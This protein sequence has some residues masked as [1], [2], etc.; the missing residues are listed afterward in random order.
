MKIT[1]IGHSC[2]KVEKDGYSV[3]IDPYEDG[4]V[5][6]L[7]PVKEQASAV[8]CSHE[9]GDHNHREGVKLVESLAKPL[10]I[11]MIDT[12]HDDAKGAMRGPNKIHIL[13]D[14]TER[15]AHLGDLGCMLDESQVEMLK[16]V[17]VLLIP[18]GGYYTI[19]AKQACELC[20]KI[21]PKLIIPMHY[22][23]DELGF[24][25]DVIAT[26]DEF[27]KLMGHVEIVG[28]S[29]IDTKEKPIAKVV[30]LLPQNHA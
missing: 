18:V 29:T 27:I 15:I 12:Y 21:A 5:P 17:D 16:N 7:L 6:G 22:R 3:V 1:W 24:G 30:V 25:Y 11:S 20:E 2:V 8:L 19:D 13:T 28:N 26:K 10:Q 14:G 9:H 4:S 23:D